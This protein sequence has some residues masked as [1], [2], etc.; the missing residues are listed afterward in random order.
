MEGQFLG[1]LRVWLS[2][3]DL[4]LGSIVSHF[5]QTHVSCLRKNEIK[6]PLLV[7][8][9]VTSSLCLVNSSRLI[10]NEQYARSGWHSQVIAEDLAPQD[11][12]QSAPQKGERSKRW[13]K[14]TCDR[15]EQSVGE[16]GKLDERDNL[17][18]VK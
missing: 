9:T 2:N 18:G 3:L 16:F 5:L 14:S 12:R 15:C 4:L 6:C 1:I 8:R 7:M 13:A 10:I 17:L 11:G